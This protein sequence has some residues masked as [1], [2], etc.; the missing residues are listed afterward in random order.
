MTLLLPAVAMMLGWGLRGFIGGGPLGAMIPGAMVALAICVTRGFSPAA[1]ACAFGAIAISFGG[2]MTY[3]QTVGAAVASE[4]R[5]WGLLGLA[6]KGGVWGLLGGG[7]MS[8]GF[9]RISARR[10][11]QIGLVLTA[12]T[13]VGWKV[14]NQ[15]KL[16]YF[17]NR[18]DRPREEVWAGFLLAGLTLV[19]WLGRS[20]PHLARFAGWGALGGGLGFGLGG[21]VQAYGIEYF[22]R[23][24]PWWK[25]MEFTFGLLLGLALAWAARQL[26]RPDEAEL[27][28]ETM[29]K[30][31]LQGASYGLI[32]LGLAGRL[33]M[34]F[35]FLILGGV[36]LWLV[37][38]S[39]S[40]GWQL[41]V[42]IPV[43]AAA[44]DLA[45]VRN[46]EWQQVAA[47]LFS[48]AFGWTVARY[49][50]TAPR[51][52]LLLTW[53]TTAIATVK[54]GVQGS[55]AENMVGVAFVAMAVA[56]TMMIRK[57]TRGPWPDAP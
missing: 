45:E 38:R 27:A 41:G 2:E 36:A 46:E 4:S 49:A 3:G 48:V 47:V 53:A 35:E 14:V 23:G 43:A 25:G 50:D 11:A 28:R 37:A 42:T 10:M 7:V 20:Q 39:P 26:P 22:G 29:G 34:R 6:V 31:L 5:A 9:A 13:W 17:S 8:L 44:M 18:L 32:L 54:F 1:R 51:A 55:G 21:A 30:S 33:P 16:I 15:P 57:F 52:L 56:M 12:A 40:G 24:Y 19:I